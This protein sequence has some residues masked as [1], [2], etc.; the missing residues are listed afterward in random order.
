MTVSTFER[1][2]RGSLNKGDRDPGEPACN[3]ADA[4]KHLLQCMSLKL[5][6]FPLS[7]SHLVCS[8]PK[9]DV[10]RPVSYDPLQTSA[11]PT[12]RTA[13]IEFET[14]NRDASRFGRFCSNA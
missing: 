3:F 1:L 2:F 11:G 5:A 10:R 12:H 9:A 4:L 8:T 7:V 6:P 13:A 14:R